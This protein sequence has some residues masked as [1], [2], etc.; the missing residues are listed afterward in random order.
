M[1]LKPLNATSHLIFFL[2]VQLHLQ[3]QLEEAELLTYLLPD[4]SFNRN[5]DKNVT[6]LSSTKK[7]TEHGKIR[8]RPDRCPTVSV[9][10]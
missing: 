9:I 3:L 10:Q 7:T 5:A 6:L 8:I 2:C 1:T 4:N